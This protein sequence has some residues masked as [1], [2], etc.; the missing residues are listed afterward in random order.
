MNSTEILKKYFGYDSFRT[1]QE[2]I[3]G[4]ILNGR[5][6]LGIM[7]TGAGKSLCYQVP[8]LMM[9]GMTLVI[10]PLIS[11]MQD[12]VNA[13]VQ[14]GI[15]AAYINSSLSS[16]ELFTVMQNARSGLYKLIYVAPERLDSDFFTDFAVNA[17]ISMITVDEAHCISQWGQDFRPGYKKIPE[18]A[19]KLPRRPVMSAFTAT[20]TERVRTDIIRLLKLA[21]PFTVVTGFDR[22][23]LYFSVRR[24]EEKLSA[25]L[26]LVKKYTAENRSGIVYCS[27]RK[28]VEYVCDNLKA[29]GYSASRY[30]AGLSEEER[31]ANQ[32]DFLYDR[33]RIMAA[34]N[35]FGMGIDKSNVSYVIHYNMPRDVESYYQEAG[36]AGR[37]GSPADCVLFYSEQDAYIANFLIKKTYEESEADKETAAAILGRDLA[38]L[39]AMEGYCSGNTCLREY[40]L[41]YFGENY[42]AHNCGNCSVCLEN[43]ELTDITVESQKIISC[44][45]RAG[46]R[47][48]VKTIIEILRGADNEKLRSRG[49]DSL[50]TYGIMRDT[51]EKQLRVMFG[52]LESRGIIFRT[53]DEYPV[54][55]VTPSAK[56]VLS[57]EVKVNARFSREKE[58]PKAQV[59][60]YEHDPV[61][62]ERLRELR[63]EIARVQSVPAYVI[64]SDTSLREMCTK[65]PCTEEDFLKIGGV[66]SVKLERFGDR[67]LSV[68]REYVKEKNPK[69]SVSY[70]TKEDKKNSSDPKNILSHLDELSP[71]DE[72]MT[73]TSFL[74]R[75]IAASGTEVKQSALRKAVYEGLM[76]MGLLCEK[77]DEQ[78]HS[79]K[80]ITES[81]AEAGIYSKWVQ[82]PSGRTYLRVQY[83]PKA[84]QLIIDKLPEFLG[85][86]RNPQAG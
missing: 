12:Q 62:M 37:D 81:S 39:R 38:R 50:S 52:V 46:Q 27:T 25:L 17:D 56:A 69:A 8:A 80:D 68:I 54:V 77:K 55:R 10:S 79:C 43:D 4:N 40:I 22:K 20:A 41:R 21:D 45:V 70:R 86:G 58:P 1:G 60:T 47:Y 82:S 29:E 7:P 71:S 67:F 24:P 59:I 30:H 18:F 23:N 26:R 42:T 66:G 48:G 33:V 5:D 75:L 16:G 14:S 85:G 49:L 36:R 61:L 13:L 9:S 78:G 2:D 6:A 53:E 63:A 74:D 64:F 11:L 32:E 76:G 83:T 34:T 3:I 19:D 35:A 28:N 15:P 57:G 72:D 84:Q 31:K 73:I 44:I 65:L 51:S